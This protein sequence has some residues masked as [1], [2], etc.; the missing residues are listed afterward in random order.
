MIDLILGLREIDGVESRMSPAAAETA[1]ILTVPSDHEAYQLDPAAGTLESS[2]SVREE[3]ECT[4]F[5]DL[6]MVVA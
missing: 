1:V 2:Q 5:R 6:S 4:L 3:L